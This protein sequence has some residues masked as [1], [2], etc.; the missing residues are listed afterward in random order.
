M[1]N[2]KECNKYMHAVL[3]IRGH[4]VWPV[5]V[6]PLNTFQTLELPFP[7]SKIE[8]VLVLFQ[9]PKLIVLN[10][11]LHC[12]IYYSRFLLICKM[13]WFHSEINSL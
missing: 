3:N 10:F 11:L 7:I 9:F 8:F 4:C 2:I 1:G 12:K 6:E 5:N 13:Y